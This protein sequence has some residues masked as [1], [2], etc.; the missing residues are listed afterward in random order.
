MKFQA[1]RISLRILAKLGF[2]AA[3]SSCFL[4]CAQAQSPNI[5]LILADDVGY[6]DLTCYGSKTVP[7]PNIDRLA[8]NGLRFTSASASSSTCTPSR[9]SL[10]TGTYAWREKG[11][12]IANGDAPLLIKPGTVTIPSML[13]QAGYRSAIIGKWH[14]GL[15][16]NPGGPQWNGT[17]TPGPLELGFDY[18][19][20][21][22]ST[23]DRVPTVLIEN[24]Q[25]VG[26]QAS[27]PI[28]ISYNNRI[29]NDGPVYED[30]EK[31]GKKI[32]LKMWP[33]PGGHRGTIVNG[34]PRI[35]YMSGGH[36][37]RW[38]DE[39]LEDIFLQKTRAFLDQNRCHP[40]FL[41]YA[42]VDIHVPRLVDA[43][44]AGKSGYGPRGDALLR[45]D[46][47]VGQMV[48]MLQDRNLINNTIILFT[49]DNGPVLDDG[50]KDCA[51]SLYGDKVPTGPLRGGKYSIFEG[52]TR[53]PL[54]VMWPKT[55]TPGR[56]SSAIVNQ[57]DF[58]A[59]F[60][61]LTNQPISNFASDHPQDSTDQSEALIGHSH[62]GREYV[63]EASS[64]LG[65]RNQANW[66]YIAPAS[67]P[68]T[69]AHIETGNSK[70][71]QAYNLN[72]DLGET[73][74]VYKQ[75]QEIVIPLKNKLEEISKGAPRDYILDFSKN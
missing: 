48:Q 15:G 27:H 10:L 73:T 33:S 11:T 72:E 21:L 43:R 29:P 17:I 8:Q 70:V 1:Q 39:N 24:R 26:L 37:A 49:S 9:Y 47:Q 2:L 7:T 44:F 3:S 36:S 13:R 52:G 55:I 4:F 56:V 61:H 23:P 67:G 32:Y 68:P 38:I 25:V 69:S 59:S 53:V 62:L 50:Y 75:S 18:D 57:V 12:G 51:R 35:G 16:P 63:V 28:R 42:S 40:F 41:W 31:N 74:N 60:A 54:I 22:P 64:G 5:V 58:L 20:L 30:Y 71:P 45:V 65:I 14:L 34:V 6:G 66:K 19:Y 46:W